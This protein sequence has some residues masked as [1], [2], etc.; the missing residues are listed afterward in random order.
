MQRRSIT[1]FSLSFLDIM[2][3]GFGA[4]VL[5][6]LIMNAN[7]VSEREQVFADHRAEI[8]RLERE[9]IVATEGLQS[10]RGE[11]EAVDL[12][13][14][15]QRTSASA[16]QLALERME[17]ETAGLEAATA[18]LRTQN[19]A[20]TTALRALEQKKTEAQEKAA[21]RERGQQ[22]HEITG[23]GER[24]YLTGLRSVSYT[25]LTLPTNREV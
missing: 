21:D 2:F 9:M 10:A 6:V 1:P 5:L 16:T 12:Q 15:T 20:A 13:L 19:R 18:A 22:L 8:V 14:E 11:L 3:C 4:V 25:H 24:Q 7:A 17:I 23:D